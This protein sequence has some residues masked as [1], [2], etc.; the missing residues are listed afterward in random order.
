LPRPEAFTEN[1]PF[2]ASLLMVIEADS[3]TPEVGW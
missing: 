2:E 1:A 3:S